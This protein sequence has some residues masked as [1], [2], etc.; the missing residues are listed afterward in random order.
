MSEPGKRYLE[1]MNEMEWHRATS[2]LNRALELKYAA[3]LDRLWVTLDE[4]EQN[5]IEREFQ[6]ID[7]AATSK[8]S[9]GDDTQ[10]SEGSSEGPRKVAA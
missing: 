1:L 10:V 7:A 8:E 9:L 3:R 4:A 2:G 5:A 6:E